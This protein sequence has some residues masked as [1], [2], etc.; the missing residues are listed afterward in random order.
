MNALNQQ[1]SGA[2]FGQFFNQANID[3]SKQS[4]A[5]IKQMPNFQIRANQSQA[6]KFGA[7]Q[8]SV[9]NG[10]PAP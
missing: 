10:Q 8:N 9:G 6:I 2:E 3:Q 1:V 4:N 5:G 7:R